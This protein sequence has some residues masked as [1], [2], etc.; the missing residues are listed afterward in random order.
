MWGFFLE[1]GFIFRS[2]PQTP[3]INCGKKLSHVCCPGMC[4]QTPKYNMFLFHCCCNPRL[5]PNHVHHRESETKAVYFYA[6]TQPDFQIQKSP[7]IPECFSPGSKAGAGVVRLVFH[8]YCV[9][10]VPYCFVFMGLMCARTFVSL[11]QDL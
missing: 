10:D 8:E 5:F 3:L 7:A 4:F 9:S 2:F 11:S 6:I 1:G